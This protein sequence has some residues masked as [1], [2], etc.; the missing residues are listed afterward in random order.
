MWRKTKRSE[1]LE[2]NCVKKFGILFIME[3][4]EVILGI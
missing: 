4:L 1:I 3:K 2:T